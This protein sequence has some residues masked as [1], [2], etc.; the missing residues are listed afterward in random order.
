MHI[1]KLLIVIFLSTTIFPVF[2]DAVIFQTDFNELPDNWYA[3][4]SWEFGS[5]GA[6]TNSSWP[7]TWWDADML[8]TNSSAGLV[9]FIPDGTDS[10]IVTIPYYL[11]SQVG[12]GSVNFNILMQASGSTWIEIWSRSLY[13][14]GSITETATI[15]TSPDWISGGEWIGIRFYGYGSCDDFGCLTV[16]WQIYGLTITAIGDSLALDNSTWAMIKSISGWE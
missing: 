13:W 11:H 8:T 3:N 4:S 12:E 5:T 16:N 10:I 9:Y 14:E 15:N 6:T 7:D 1:K 2:S